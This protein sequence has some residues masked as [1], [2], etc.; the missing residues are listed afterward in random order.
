MADG[1]GASL[2]GSALPA[3]ESVAAWEAFVRALTSDAVVPLEILDADGNPTPTL[4]GGPVSGGDVVRIRARA[5]AGG[6]R[7]RVRRAG[8]EARLAKAIESSK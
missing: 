4:P 2:A 7:R 6:R 1:G 3:R 5:R 8:Y